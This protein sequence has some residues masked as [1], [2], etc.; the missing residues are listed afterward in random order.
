[1]I[2]QLGSLKVS[3]IT[4]AQS[5]KITD[6][7]TRAG[8]RE[9]PIHPAI[10]SLVERLKNDAMTPYLIPSDSENQY[11]DRGDALG[12]RFGRLKKSLG[13]NDRSQV[14][15]SIRKTL[16]TLMENAGVSEGVA[17]DIV[18]HEKQTMTYGLYSMGSE[19][20]IKREALAKARYP[21]PL[22]D[23]K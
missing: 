2:G 23:I 22:V 1:M 11:D 20:E 13:F 14:F 16:I 21:A 3:D 18:G 9:I 5:F 12:K 6:S 4:D 10:Q 17:A 8:I 19:L 15:H 7:K